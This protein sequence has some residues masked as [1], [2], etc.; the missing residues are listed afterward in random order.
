MQVCW[1]G[2]KHTASRCEEDL[3]RIVAIAIHNKETAS[4][5]FTFDHLVLPQLFSPVG[6]VSATQFEVSLDWTRE[7]SECVGDID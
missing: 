5:S 4:Q 1:Y 6:E 7:D 3:F 2:Q